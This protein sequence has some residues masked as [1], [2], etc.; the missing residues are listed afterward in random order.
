MSEFRDDYQDILDELE[1]E[2]LNMD[3]FTPW[4]PEEDY[5][6]DYELGMETMGL[7]GEEDEQGLSERYWREAESRL[8]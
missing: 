3:G 2:D 8:Q 1:R 7:S 6:E 5:D 4:L